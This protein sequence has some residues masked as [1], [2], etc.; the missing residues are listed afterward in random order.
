LSAQKLKLDKNARFK[1]ENIIILLFKM[2]QL[3]KRNVAWNFS[4]FSVQNNL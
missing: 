1:N 4:S 2:K 3:S